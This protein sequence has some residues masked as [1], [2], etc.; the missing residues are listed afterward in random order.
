MLRRREK[1]LELSTNPGEE[2]E[3]HQKERLVNYKAVVET[4]ILVNP[5]HGQVKTE[6]TWNPPE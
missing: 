4:V 5:I 2:E 6:M 1:Y 3:V